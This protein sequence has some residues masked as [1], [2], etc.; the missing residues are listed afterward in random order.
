MFAGP[1]PSVAGRVAHVR[2]YYPDAS[3][4]L[5]RAHMAE[6][7]F[8]A[9]PSW[10]APRAPSQAIRARMKALGMKVSELSAEINRD[11]EFYIHGGMDDGA[12]VPAALADALPPDPTDADAA[13]DLARRASERGEDMTET[14]E[15]YEFHG[16]GQGGISWL[17]RD[18]AREM[19][20]HAR[21]H[22]AAATWWDGLA[23]AARDNLRKRTSDLIGSQTK[24]ERLSLAN[25]LTLCGALKCTTEYLQGFTADPKEEAAALSVEQAR[26]AYAELDP[27]ARECVTSVMLSLVYHG[28]GNS[29]YADAGD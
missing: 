10:M 20:A 4:P 9:A 23:P 22:A 24:L 1:I 3:H 6:A 7:P 12:R 11:G 27:Y 21:R 17:D 25:V 13:A 19:L 8:S 15:G 16:V 5:R 14:P 2:Y 18:T 26:A 29:T 28:A